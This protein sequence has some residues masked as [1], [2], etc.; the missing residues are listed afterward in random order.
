M[1]NV[2]ENGDITMTVNPSYDLKHHFFVSPEEL[3]SM[4]IAVYI[5][6]T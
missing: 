1:H 4:V 5:L 6:Y 2:T 3:Y